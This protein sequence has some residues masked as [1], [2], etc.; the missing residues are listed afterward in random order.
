MVDSIS[1]DWQ[2]IDPK[3]TLDHHDRVHP[4]YSGHFV[5]AYSFVKSLDFKPLYS[6][7]V[8]DKK[9]Q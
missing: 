2:K 3:I 1:L 4:K 8:I 5:M 9:I 6:N 7:T